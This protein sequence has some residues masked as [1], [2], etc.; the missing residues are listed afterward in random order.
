[1]RYSKFDFVEM[2]IVHKFVSDGRVWRKRRGGRKCSVTWSDSVWSVFHSVFFRYDPQWLS[3][4]NLSCVSEVETSHVN[5][6]CCEKILVL[7]FPILTSIPLDINITFTFVFI[8]IIY[9]PYTYSHVSRNVWRNLKVEK[10]VLTYTRV[11]ENKKVPNY[12]CLKSFLTD[13]KYWQ[14]LQSFENT[15]IQK[16]YQSNR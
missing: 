9:F 16:H 10:A 5:R 12:W 6:Y 3:K 2:V 4:S 14:Y 13:S 11:T 7:L 8:Y 1:M 15:N